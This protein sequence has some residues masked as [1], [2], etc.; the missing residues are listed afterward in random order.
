MR[1]RHG[2]RGESGKL[3]ALLFLGCLAIGILWTV[4]T[5]TAVREHREVRLVDPWAEEA[6]FTYEPFATDGRPLATGEP[7]YFTTEAP[8]VRVGFAWDL[9]DP[10]S[11]S[12]TAAGTLSLVVHHEADRGAWSH[13]E[14]IAN[15]TRVGAPGEPLRLVGEV[16]LAKVADALRDAGRAEDEAT[17]T[18]VASVAFAAS[19][20]HA[21]DAS[22]FTLPFRH[23]PP[24]Y[25]FPPDDALTLA[26]D[27]AQ[28]ESLVRVERPGV[29]ALAERPLAPALLLA[30]ALGAF[31]SFRALI[32]EETA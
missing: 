24:L 2:P 23:T 21:S 7:G 9:A 32:E 29:G 6:T 1:W 14:P 19:S 28:R 10:T 8:R 22:E 25:T 26:K 20:T 15:A 13:V 4:D 3:L 16:D 30:G 11:T 17:W 12:Y 31:W 5:V 18:F 27:H